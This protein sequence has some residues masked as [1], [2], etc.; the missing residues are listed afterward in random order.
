MASVTDSGVLTL[1]LPDAGAR[2]RIAHDLDT[3]LLVEAGAGSG[4]TWELVSRMTALIRSGRAKIDQVAAVTF[5]RKAAGELKQRFQIRM[6]E[7]LRRERAEPAPDEVVVERLG[8]AL[9]NIDRA[10]VGTIHSFCA[11][12]LRERPLEIGLD[13]GFQELPVEERVGLRSRFWESYL[14]RLTRDSDPI[15]EDLSRAGI[16]PALLT[17]AFEHLVENPDVDFPAEDAE[18][19]SSADLAPIR[20]ELEAVVDLGW[21]LMPEREPTPKWDSLQKK[22]RTLHFTRDVTGWREPADL[23]EGLA[24]LCK[25]GPK[26]HRITQKRWRDKALAKALC[27]RVDDFFVGDTAARRM[28]EQWYAHR[29]ALSIRLCSHAAEEYAAH[30][31]RIGRLDF[32]DLLVL[33]ARLLRSNA[34]VRSQLG[35]RYRYLLVDEFQ[36][37]DPLQAEIVLLLASEPTGGTEDDAAEDSR[38]GSP[39]EESPDADWRL[40]IPRP[41]A[42][43]VVGDPKQSIYRFRRADIQLYSLVKKRFADFGAVVELTA[44]FR[45]RPPLGD[46]VNE[47]FLGPGFFPEEATEAQ[48]AFEPLNTRPSSESVVREGVFVYDIAPDETNKAAAADDDAGRIAT[49]IRDRIDRGEREAGDFMILTR[50]KGRLATYARALEARSIPIQVTGAGVGVEEEIGELHIVLECMIDPANPVKV[51]AALV[52]LFFGLDYEQLV[53]HRLGGGSLDVMRPGVRGHSEVLEAL[54]ALHNWWGAAKSEPADIFVSRLVNEL[55]LLPYAAAGDLGT[56]RAGALVYALDAVRA[57]A[58][59][60]DSSLPGALAALRAALAVSEAE[61]PLEPGRGDVVRLMNLHQ[62]KGLE[63]TVVVLADPSEWKDRKPSLHTVRRPD[64]GAHGFLRVVEASTGFGGDRIMAVPVGWPEKEAAEI[65]FTEAEDVRLTYVAVT[66]AREELVVARWPGGRGTS[67]WASLDPWLEE[68]AEVLQMEVREPEPRERLELSPEESEQASRDATER[69]A[70]MAEPTFRHTS[71]TGLVKSGDRGDA[72]APRRGDGAPDTA[73]RGL[74]WGSVV[75]GALAAAAQEGSTDEGLRATCRDLLVEY[76]RPLDDHGEPRELAELLELVGAVRAS[77][78]WQRARAAKRHL[79]E[80]PFATPYLA[81]D[82]D[83]PRSEDARAAPSSPRRQLDLFSVPSRL[84]EVEA[85]TAA[86]GPVES[87]VRV[88]EGVIDL[89]FWESDGWVI[90]D[91]KT[92]VGTDPDFGQRSEAYRRQVELYAEAWAS[93]TG[94][95][96]KERVLFYTSQARV[97]SW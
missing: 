36:D 60:G 17:Q 21:E 52:G 58:L 20:E 74:S 38:D 11:K 70:A 50:V 57:A 84:Q 34:L 69:L 35:E 76:A 3:N 9:E 41:G 81:K 32:Q 97:E 44:N 1:P 63:A 43:F 19:P 92:D 75:H 49:W 68:R 12:L 46:L 67:A 16:R 45:S 95:R 42:L 40:A 78:L 83:P 27:Q 61:A 86:V 66:R 18:P 72:R 53:A 28:L 5:T 48:A 25:S 55:G 7:E 88:L 89:A 39:S 96:V 8:R 85:S 64:G 94:E 80:V 2:E 13:P 87:G 51:V 91:Y 73:F 30:R 71:V 24:Q 54:R 15:L 37:T 22:L 62:A 93:L 65:A 10:F 82:G 33:A 6:E 31:L 26:G 29:Y 77:K 79:V 14:E 4:K 23:F 47:H 59:G 56:L 90:A